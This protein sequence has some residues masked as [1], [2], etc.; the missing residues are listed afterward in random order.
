MKSISPLINETLTE[1]KSLD[2]LAERLNLSPSGLRGRI[3]RGYKKWTMQELL[4]MAMYLGY[5]F[6]YVTY[7]NKMKMDYFED[8]VE[9]LPV[10][11]KQLAIMMDMSTTT[12][13]SRLANGFTDIH[14]ITKLKEIINELTPFQLYEGYY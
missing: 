13:S 7:Y 12:L 14:E 5:K 8:Y 9:F 2:E 3:E 10:T 6:D 1:E 11:Q 4:E